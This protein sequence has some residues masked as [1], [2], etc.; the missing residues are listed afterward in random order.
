[1]N[2]FRSGNGMKSGEKAVNFAPALSLIREASLGRRRLR[3]MI[4]TDSS[5]FSWF[6]HRNP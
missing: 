5:L 6:C 2:R 4:H 1:M 3:V